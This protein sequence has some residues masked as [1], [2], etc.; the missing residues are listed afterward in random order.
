[1]TKKTVMILE[2]LRV[3]LLVVLLATSMTGYFG[4]HSLTVPIV[5]VL[6]VMLLARLGIRKLKKKVVEENHV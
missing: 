5:E 1:M 4:W 6:F 2:N 3:G